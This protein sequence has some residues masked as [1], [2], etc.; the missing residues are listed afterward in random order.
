MKLTARIP[1]SEAMRAGAAASTRSTRSSLQGK[2]GELRIVAEHLDRIE[3]ELGQVVTDQAQLLE[4]IPGHRNDGTPYRLG[5]KDIQQLTRA[6]P[7]ELGL[8][9]LTQH[10]HG[11]RHDRN[12]I[13]A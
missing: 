4:D 10:L 5:L 1:S 8:R 11:P 9:V 7:D 13:H 3:R 12:R 6:G 2:A